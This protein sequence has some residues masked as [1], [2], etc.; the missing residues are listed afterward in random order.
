[1]RSNDPLT[2]SSFCDDAGARDSISLP[3]SE[4]P[5]VGLAL[6]TTQE[7]WGVDK[8][9]QIGVQ[10]WQVGLSQSANALGRLKSGRENER[11]YLLADPCEW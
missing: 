5:T 1:M 6:M 9:E 4:S 10:K 3:A 11:S 2:P 7:R 8:L